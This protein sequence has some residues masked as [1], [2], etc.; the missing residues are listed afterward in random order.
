MEI[1]PVGTELY[2]ADGH[3]DSRVIGRQTEWVSDWLI[4]WHTDWLTDMAKPVV[5]F[6]NFA[7]APE[8]NTFPTNNTY[9]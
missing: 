3:T 9:M 8:S 2:Y 5:A 4:D 6:R 7:S 1:R